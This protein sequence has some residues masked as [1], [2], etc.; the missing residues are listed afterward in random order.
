LCCKVG[1]WVF[2]VDSKLSQWFLLPF[3]VALCV[4]PSHSPIKLCHFVVFLVLDVSVNLIF[5]F[6][7][8]S[9]LHIDI[10]FWI[11]S[12]FI[13]CYKLKRFMNFCVAIYFCYYYNVTKYNDFIFFLLW[14]WRV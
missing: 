14:K 4:Q 7:L 2:Y 8:F 10:L 11:L 12:L 1:R 6:F 5:I 3:Q 13:F 9:C